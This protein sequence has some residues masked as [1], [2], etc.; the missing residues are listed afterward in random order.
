MVRIPHSLPRCA[1][2]T[3]CSGCRRPHPPPLLAGPAPP[4]SPPSNPHR[5]DTALLPGAALPATPL[6]P[7]LHAFLV[8]FPDVIHFMFSKVGSD[9]TMDATCRKLFSVFRRRVLCLLNQTTK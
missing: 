5:R 4:E 7:Y 8:G 6:Q 1:A 2:A 3:C 9:L